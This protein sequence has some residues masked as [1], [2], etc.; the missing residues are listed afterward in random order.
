M[1]GVENVKIYQY[2]DRLIQLSKELIFY[3][4]KTGSTKEDAQD[5]AQEVPFI[6]PTK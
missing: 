5:I 4:I 1:R 3:L 2:E 6:Q